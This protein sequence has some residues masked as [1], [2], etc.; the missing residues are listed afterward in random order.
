[1]PIVATFKFPGKLIPD[2]LGYFRTDLTVIKLVHTL[3]INIE[4]L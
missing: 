2:E 1:M 4:I 3:K